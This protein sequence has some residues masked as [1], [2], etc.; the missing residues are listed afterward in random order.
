VVEGIGLYME[1]VSTSRKDP[2]DVSSVRFVLAETDGAARVMV[3]EI[4]DGLVRRG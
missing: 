2:E 1:D 3:V 4:D